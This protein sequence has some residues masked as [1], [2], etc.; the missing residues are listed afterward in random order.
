MLSGADMLRPLVA[1]MRAALWGVIGV[2]ESPRGQLRSAGVGKA[3]C[4]GARHSVQRGQHRA[5]QMLGRVRDGGTGL[6]GKH[7]RSFGRE[8]PPEVCGTMVRPPRRAA[9][10]VD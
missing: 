3:S 7:H 5:C 4:S 1:T 2:C 9:P 6:W 8:M 10:Q